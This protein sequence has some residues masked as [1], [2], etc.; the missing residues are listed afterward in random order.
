MN[1]YFSIPG[2]LL[3]RPSG[4][5]PCRVRGK[6]LWAC[7]QYNTLLSLVRFLK[8]IRGA[9]LRF[10]T[11][12]FFCPSNL[13]R[14]HLITTQNSPALVDSMHPFINLAR[15]ALHRVN[16]MSQ[17]QLDHSI[18]VLSHLPLAW[19]ET[20]SSVLPL[21]VKE[22]GTEQGPPLRQKGQIKVPHYDKKDR[23]RSLITTK[24]T[25]QGPPLR[26]KGQIKVPNRGHFS[27]LSFRN[28]LA[29]KTSAGPGPCRP[30]VH[31]GPSAGQWNRQ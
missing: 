30:T 5:V 22:R 8:K 18:L 19:A 29:P 27:V 12:S 15:I 1:T 11:G 6:D 9:C 4:A 17:S 28:L 3:L 16:Y 23:S 20:S 25:D 26:Q 2:A 13:C 10:C 14:S 21:F 24:R 31:S 7:K